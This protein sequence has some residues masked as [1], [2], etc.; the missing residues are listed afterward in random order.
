MKK[1]LFVILA[2]T[3]LISCSGDSYVTR[4]PYLNAGNFSAPIDMSLPA[5]NNLRYT[6]NPVVVNVDGWGI[7]GLI[8]MNTGSGYVAWENSCPNQELSSCSVLRVS[9]AYATCPCDN[10]QYSLFT[11]QPTTPMKYNL[12]AYRVEILSDT[13]IRVYN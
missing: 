3:A 1:L 4:N 11:G 8:V 13:A 2:V 7:N 9:G 10:V 5:Y 6:A 12:K